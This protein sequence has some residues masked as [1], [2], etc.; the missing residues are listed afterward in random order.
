MNTRKLCKTIAGAAI[1]SFSL[2]N[3]T[4][5][6]TVDFA[7]NGIS[8][9]PLSASGGEIISGDY[10]FLSGAP[11]GVVNGSSYAA[12][13]VNNATNM[14]VFLNQSVLTIRR[15]DYGL[16][17]LSSL[18]AGGWLNLPSSS[19]A[20]LSITGQLQGGGQVSFSGPA[21]PPG[22]SITTFDHLTAPASFSNLASLTL[23][24]TGYSSS[25]YAAIDN[26]VLTPVP[27]P[28]T[29][30]TLLAGLWLIGAVARRHRAR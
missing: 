13:G 24:M 4:T 26:L 25:A 3:A 21:S 8:S 17:G 27:E 14:L 19:N 20:Q 10:S 22:L 6:A 18:D 28:A 2:T 29:F 7:A 12:F 23:T 1:L 16:F 9:L 15:V 30:A 5:A 11:L